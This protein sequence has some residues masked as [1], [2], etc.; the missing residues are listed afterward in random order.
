MRTKRDLRISV[1]FTNHKLIT[2]FL[3]NVIVFISTTILYFTLIFSVFNFGGNYVNKISR[4]NE[5]KTEYRLNL[6]EGLD[7]TEY[8]KIIQDFYF[9][10]YP[11]EITKAYNTRYNEE[12][13]IT[14][15]Y[16]IIVLN[17]PINP[18]NES[19]STDYYKYAQNSDGTFNVEVLAERIILDN[20][21]KTYYKNMSD[22]FYNAYTDL[23]PYLRTFNAEYNSLYNDVAALEMSARIISFLVSILIFYYIIPLT[24]KYGSTL[25][26]KVYKL[27]HSNYING[28][29]VPRWKIALR[30]IIYF[31][32]P[33]IGIVYF[34]R[35]TIIIFI[36]AYLALNLLILLV[37]KKNLDFADK[38]LKMNTCYINESLLFKN[39]AEEEAYFESEEGKKI[40]DVDFVSTLENMDA[41]NVTS[42]QEKERKL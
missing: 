15:I 10:K 1:A 42:P 34:T 32:I 28:Y 16:N 25:I 23:E 19:Y 24:N 27:G 6:G 20:P 7:Y 9:N 17:L 30:P 41:L 39:R 36:I 38:I 21:S 26:E 31:L 4:I 33:F 3:D 37:S 35:N 5:I 40:T 13:T 11:N 29:L 2:V 18:T 22:L 14:H 8:E 12:K